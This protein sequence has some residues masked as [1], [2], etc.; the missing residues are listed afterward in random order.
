MDV[1]VGEGSCLVI[2]DTG[3]PI[4]WGLQTEPPRGLSNVV[5]FV[6]G[7][8]W[9]NLAIYLNELRISSLEFTRPNATI[10]FRSFRDRQYS[11]EYSD[12]LAPIEWLPLTDATVSGDGHY[13]QIT[14]P[15]ATPG[16]SRFYRLQ[17]H[18]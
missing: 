8:W 14:G 7:A 2:K 10:G 6:H 1:A 4:V 9:G 16:G 12:N 13:I 18:P 17:R 11:V 5:A 3:E 15:G